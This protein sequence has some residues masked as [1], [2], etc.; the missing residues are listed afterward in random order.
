MD[1]EVEGELDSCP[2]QGSPG[3]P[4]FAYVPRISSWVLSVSSPCTLAALQEYRPWSEKDTLESSREPSCRWWGEPSLL[5]FL[6][7]VT[8]ASGT[9]RKKKQNSSA[10]P[11]QVTLEASAASWRA[12]QG[13]LGGSISLGVLDHSGAKLNNASDHSIVWRALGFSNVH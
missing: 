12:L 8:S 5:L 10:E 13:C 4:A 11:V 2:Q 3:R 7:Q 6:N 1:E 9:P